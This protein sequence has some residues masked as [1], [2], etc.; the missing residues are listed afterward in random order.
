MIITKSIKIEVNGFMVQRYKEMGF[1]VKE[2]DIINLPVENLSKYSH[3]YILC[4]CDMCGAEKEIKFNNYSKYIGADNIYTCKICN[5]EKRKKTCKE[6]YGVENVSKLESVKTKVKKTMK[7]NGTYRG[8]GTQHHKDKMIELYGVENASQS[9][10]IHEKQHGFTLKYHEN[11]IYYRGSYEKD[12]IDF[13]LR[14]N[15]KIEN[16]RKAIWF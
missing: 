2:H 13:C 11:G 6:R 15:I 7:D 5:L 12:F 8:F 3:Q 9:L 1:N 10:E 4:A 14:N 16:F